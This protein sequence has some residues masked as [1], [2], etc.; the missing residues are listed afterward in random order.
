MQKETNIMLDKISA[1]QSEMDKK[2][3]D[4]FLN[5]EIL[6]PILQKTVEEYK[7]LSVAEIIELIDEDS[8]SDLEAVSDFPISKNIKIEQIDTD[9]KSVTDKLVLYDIHFKAALPKDRRSKLNFRLYIDFEPQGKYHLSYPLIKRAMYYVARG[10]SIQL[11]ELTDR[12]GR[13]LK[14]SLRRWIT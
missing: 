13:C 8:I 1:A 6:A 10:L 9:L 12:P 7:G 11:G 14:I 3:H 5:K 2:C 4:L